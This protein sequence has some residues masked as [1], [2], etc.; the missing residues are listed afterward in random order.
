MK[1]NVTI[2]G[3]IFTVAVVIYIGFSSN[4]IELVPG[5][6]MHHLVKI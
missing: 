2:I 3:L 4:T 6:K 5:E 1:K